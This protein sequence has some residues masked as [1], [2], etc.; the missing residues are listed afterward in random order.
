MT[1]VRRSYDVLS[2]EKRKKCIQE[3]IS[4]F[5]DERDED[6]GIIAAED[7]LNSFLQIVGFDLYNKGIDDAKDFLKNRLEDAEIDID[8]LLKK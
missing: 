2:E 1:A 8:A 7:L 5:K 4:L 3:I 6:I